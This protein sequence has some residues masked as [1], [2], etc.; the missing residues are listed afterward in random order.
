M[1]KFFLI[2][3]F[4]MATVLSVNAETAYVA[5]KPFDNFYFGIGGGAAIPARLK[6]IPPVN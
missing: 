2:F 3:A 5:Q 6:G 4:I 1:K